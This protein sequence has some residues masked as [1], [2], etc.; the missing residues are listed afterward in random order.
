MRLFSFV[1]GAFG[2]LVL[3]AY[4]VHGAELRIFGS[5]VTRM[6]VEDTARNLSGPQAI[7]WSYSQMSPPS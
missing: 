1:C 2:L 6:I 5:R 7:D 3:A 4:P